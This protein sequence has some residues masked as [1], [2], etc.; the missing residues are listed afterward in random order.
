MKQLKKT[1]MGIFLAG[2]I[3]FTLNNFIGSYEFD[4]DKIQ[5]Y[6]DSTPELVDKGDTLA[7]GFIN[8]TTEYHSQNSV[9]FSNVFTFNDAL[10]DIIGIHNS[11]ISA[12]LVEIRPQQLGAVGQRRSERH[13]ESPVER[14]D[15]P[16]AQPG[17]RGR[18]GQLCAACGVHSLCG[19]TTT[20]SALHGF[21]RRYVSEGR[22]NRSPGSDGLLWDDI[23]RS[24]CDAHR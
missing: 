13:P 2:I 7:N 15:A 16:G 10:T 17:I 11:N 6:F 14:E 18:D 19:R 23:P 24:H 20:A 3:V 5:S 8:A 1:G 21:G 22:G 12:E 9:D 4:S